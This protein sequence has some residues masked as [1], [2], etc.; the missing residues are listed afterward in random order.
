MSDYDFMV[1]QPAVFKQAKREVIGNGSFKNRQSGKLRKQGL[2]T[3]RQIHNFL[4]LVIIQTFGKM[5]KKIITSLVS[6]AS[7]FP[8]MSSDTML[9]FLSNVYSL[10][11]SLGMVFCVVSTRYIYSYT[12]ILVIACLCIYAMLYEY[13]CRN[14][15]G[16]SIRDADATEINSLVHLELLIQNPHIMENSEKLASVRSDLLRHPRSIDVETAATPRLVSKVVDSADDKATIS[17]SNI[18]ATQVRNGEVEKIKDI[19]PSPFLPRLGSSGTAGGGLGTPMQNTPRVQSPSKIVDLSP[20]RFRNE[21]SSLPIDKSDSHRHKRV[22][23]VGEVPSLRQLSPGVEEPLKKVDEKIVAVSPSK[24]D[25]H[26]ESPSKQIK[27][28]DR[29]LSGVVVENAGGDVNDNSSPRKKKLKVSLDDYKNYRVLVATMLKYKELE[30]L[31]ADGSFK[32]VAEHQVIKH[33]VCTSLQKAEGANADNKISEGSVEYKK[34]YKF[35]EKVLKRMIE[36]ERSVLVNGGCSVAGGEHSGEG[37]A[38]VFCII[39]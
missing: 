27:H 36:K 28:L 30:A 37:H 8:Y 12:P 22:V 32:G 31:R 4:T 10:V 25:K 20:V 15:S 11:M 2:S 39:F 33:C 14:S 7:W 29:Y 3:F 18:P 13:D 24:M 21:I 35:F 38:L 26:L 34:M 19:V 23:P 16:R 1:V 9:Y 6:S 17:A 5:N